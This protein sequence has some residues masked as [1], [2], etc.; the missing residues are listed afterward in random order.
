MTAKL[1]VLDL[2]NVALRSVT[3]GIAF[4]FPVPAFT[5]SEKL[6]RWLGTVV[7]W[8]CKN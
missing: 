8:L 1:K 2:L 3:F 6:I 4:L 7:G 5:Y